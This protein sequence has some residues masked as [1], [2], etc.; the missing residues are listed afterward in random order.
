MRESYYIIA[1]QPST[2]RSS[3]AAPLHARHPTRYFF[4][5]APP[6]LDS[7][8][9]GLHADFGTRD[10]NG[11]PARM[12][13]VVLSCGDLGIEIAN[14]LAQDGAADVVG[15]F[16]T[17][18]K[19]PQRT[20]AGKL[21]HVYRMQGWTGI[22]KVAAA[23]VGSLIF[24]RDASAIDRRDPALSSNVP[25]YAFTDFHDSEARAA[26][27]DLKPDLGV[28]AGTYILKDSVF[29][30][31]RLGSINLHS[32]NVPRYR[33]AAPA[34]WEIYNGEKSVGITIHRV[35][36]SVDAGHVLSQEEF[37]VDTAPAGDPIEYIDE[38]RRDV[39]RPNGVR[40][41]VSTVRALAEG[42]EI[43]T[44]Q[45]AALAHTYKTPDHRAVRELRRLV[46]E[47]RGQLR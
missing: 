27:A 37:P 20:I 10:M 38:F 15:L 30:I 23:K 18:Y 25:L 8:E 13:A 17:P 16:M 1:A 2:L 11:E 34:F 7:R 4:P 28:I 31:P 19:V 32:G 39:L 35:A 12:R 3:H 21:S 44:P 29:L 14:A 47:R 33:G 42:R 5:A 6:P 26:L 41:I 45:D 43:E 24:R 46:R 36:A 22:P 9:P 40:M